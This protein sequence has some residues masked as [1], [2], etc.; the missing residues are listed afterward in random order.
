MNGRRSRIYVI[1]TLGLGFISATMTSAQDQRSIGLR[2]HYRADS[3]DPGAWT[4]QETLPQY[5]HI[6]L[7]KFPRR[8]NSLD[9]YRNTVWSSVVRRP[10]DS[11]AAS[12]FGPRIDRMIERLRRDDRQEAYGIWRNVL[13]DLLEYGDQVDLHDVILYLARESCLHQEPALVFHATRV[14]HLRDAWVELSNYMAELNA[15]SLPP[16]CGVHVRT[17]F[18]TEIL[19][20]Q[21]E[22]R[23]LAVKEIAAQRE[24][25]SLMR[26]RSPCLTRFCGVI[27]ELTA[28][29]LEYVN[30]RC[31][32]SCH[33]HYHDGQRLVS[34]ANHRHGNNC[35]HRWNGKHWV[36]P[37]F[38]DMLDGHTCSRN[39]RN[40]YHDG[41]R[42]VYLKNHRH[43]SGC[44]HTWN[45]G[46][47]ITKPHTC[48]E[49][50]RSC[51]YDGSQRLVLTG[52]KHSRNCGH[53]WNGRHWVVALTDN[54]LNDH[55]CS[56]G[57][58]NHYFDGDRFIVV[59]NHRHGDD[60]GH[61]WTGSRWEVRQ[62]RMAPH[63]CSR[64][65]KSCFYDGKRV[66]KL[67]RH[68]HSSNCGHKW[69]GT[70]WIEFRAGVDNGGPHR[71]TRECTNHVYDG[72]RVITLKGHTH[73]SRCGHRW[74]GTHW[75][76]S[77]T[78]SRRP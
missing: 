65:C 15:I 74:D 14:A 68:V 62:A 3:Y 41:Q 19:R 12:P 54:M 44:G 49:S 5:R 27:D 20:A 17:D 77:R 31:T 58:R 21:T 23:I 76:S 43:G 75:V 56:R 39:C 50:C 25:E 67:K 52:H 32:Q 71:C 7:M 47:W 51:F 13:S 4:Y 24:L 61:T 59:R 48:S 34:L 26:S 60:C 10:G 35:N 78:K 38:E 22:L 72:N 69:D 18:Q 11:A 73:G 1:L 16:D 6:R 46:Q 66:V 28:L 55:V 29:S 36:T 42:L 37:V 45:N 33:H 64:Q 30:H 70:Y 57:C 8:N 63:V 53:R 40:H 9:A 2:S